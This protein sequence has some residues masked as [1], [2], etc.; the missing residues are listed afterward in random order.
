MRRSDADL[1]VRTV[2]PRDSQPRNILAR[3]KI[4]ADI[5][6][7]DN[8]QGIARGQRGEL[9][10]DAVEERIAKSSDADDGGEERTQGINKKQ[11]H[12]LREPIFCGVGRRGV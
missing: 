1:K 2:R 10:H 12:V 6:Y 9:Y 7:N 5:I 4:R 8:S 11:S 3:A